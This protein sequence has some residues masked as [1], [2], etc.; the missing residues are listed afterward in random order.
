MR[1]PTANDRLQDVVDDAVG[2]MRHGLDMDSLDGLRSSRIKI[3][4]V[5]EMIGERF[6]QAG[7]RRHQEQT[8][9][10]KAAVPE[11]IGGS[12]PVTLMDL[13]V[14]RPDQHG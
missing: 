10:M 6:L 4:I 5:P 13:E 7:H 2:V 1:K 14:Q 9:E 3:E 11:G 8:M 12:R